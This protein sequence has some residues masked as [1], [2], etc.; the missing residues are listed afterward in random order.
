MVF[1]RCLS[2][3]FGRADNLTREFPDSDIRIGLCRSPDRKEKTCTYVSS[4]WKKIT[5][6]NV[7]IKG[8]SQKIQ[9]LTFNAR[10]LPSGPVFAP[11]RKRLRSRA[12]S[13]SR[14]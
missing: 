10:N 9:Q 14:K 1:L 4:R 5:E 11:L 13:R 8:V 3:G 2:R 12:E 6:L 7:K